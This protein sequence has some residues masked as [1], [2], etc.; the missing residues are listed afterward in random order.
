L[1]KEKVLAHPSLTEEDFMLVL[2][3]KAGESIVI[4]DQITITVL[5]I[6][7][8]KIRLGVEAPREVPVDRAEVHARRMEFADVDLPA[9]RG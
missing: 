9:S 6:E 3:R 8:S 5:A 2:T 4:D 1:L 7:G